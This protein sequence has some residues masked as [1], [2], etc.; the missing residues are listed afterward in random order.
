MDVVL[1]F[2][3]HEGLPAS[4]TIRIIQTP[5]INEFPEV[6]RQPERPEGKAETEKEPSKSSIK[7]R[8][9]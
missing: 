5:K 4:Y 6:T 8:M 9:R 2:D 7:T 1:L 3:V